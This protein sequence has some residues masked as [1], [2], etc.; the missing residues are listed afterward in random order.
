[1]TRPPIPDE[2]CQELL[3]L[4]SATLYEAS[5]L[6]CALPHTVQASWSGATLVGRA[7]PVSTDPGDNLPLHIALEAATAGDV[8]VVAGHGTSRG[9]WGEVMT[10]AAIARGAAG[11]VIDGCVR[12]V[13]AIAALGF[14]VFATGR[15]IVGTVKASR[16]T[17]GE[18]ITL[19]RARVA[20]GDVVVGD[21]DG[22]VAIPDERFDE[23]L[24]ASRARAAIEDAYMARL[25][26]GELTMDIYDLRT[27][28]T[29]P[30]GHE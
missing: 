21:G 7:L 11:L 29:A 9:Y 18:A 1:V 4:G 19:G 6:E 22:L 2:V 12:D 26:Q 16:G 13:A 23:V 14:P 5:N 17:V 8:L 24:T 27:L 30:S 20:A 3:A 28:G 25:R 10:V 15:S